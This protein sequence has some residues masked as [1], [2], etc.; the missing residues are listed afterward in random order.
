[1]IQICCKFSFVVSL[2]VLQFSFSLCAWSLAE[3]TAVIYA[4]QIFSSSSLDS[5]TVAGI[6]MQMTTRCCFEITNL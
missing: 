5:F 1:M 3:L 2:S 4:K 6:N